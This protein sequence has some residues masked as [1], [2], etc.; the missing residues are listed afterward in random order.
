MAVASEADA[1]SGGDATRA[2]LGFSTIALAWTA[3]GDGQ[4]DV[5]CGGDAAGL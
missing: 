4:I 2:W 5:A 1:A 3:V